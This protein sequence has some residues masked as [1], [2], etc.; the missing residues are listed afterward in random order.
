M[1][2]TRVYR[3]SSSHRLHADCLPDDC[4]R[5]IYGKCNNPF[6]HGHNYVLHV[7]V[8]G[9]VDG[10]SGRVVNVGDLDRFIAEQGLDTFDHK[11]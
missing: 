9:P 1:Q 8:E 6:G 11:V 3:F 4:N 7:S 2:L 5:E 10:A